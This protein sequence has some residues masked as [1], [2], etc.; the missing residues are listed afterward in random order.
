MPRRRLLP[1]VKELRRRLG[2][3]KFGELGKVIAA[4]GVTR[5]TVYAVRTDD[6]RVPRPK[7][8]EALTT[9]LDKLHPIRRRAPA[10][11]LEVQSTMTT[12]QFLPS[13]EMVETY[14]APA[15]HE[16]DMAAHLYSSEYRV[17]LDQ[18][19]YNAVDALSRGE[20]LEAALACIRDENV[21][22]EYEKHP[23]ADHVRAAF[24]ALPPYGE[25][26]ARA[27]AYEPI[28]EHWYAVNARRPHDL[29]LPPVAAAVHA[30]VQ[31]PDATPW[32]PGHEPDWRDLGDELQRLHGRVRGESGAGLGA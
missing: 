20:T 15:L 17:D 30:L 25:F 27:E 7:T 24:A 4:A 9:A 32:L 8:L 10:N 18:Y 29:E 19:V 12:T 31:D 14:A 21:R 3:L 16:C 13:V 23:H 5:A 22:G 28:F 6:K 2:R 1:A 11:S 26:M